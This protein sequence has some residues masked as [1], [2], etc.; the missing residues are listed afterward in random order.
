MAKK[1]LSAG[2]QDYE[3]KRAAKAG[4]SLDRW[5]AAKDRQSQADERARLLAAAPSKPVKPPGLIRRLIDRA[6]VP[7]KTKAGPQGEPRTGSPP[8]PDS[9][10]PRSTRLPPSRSR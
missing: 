6:H 7:L 5:L 1:T 3:A 2:Q 4:M 9:I 8:K 10:K